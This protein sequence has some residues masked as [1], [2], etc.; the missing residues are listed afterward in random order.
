M[1]VE[2][3]GRL[4]AE[5]IEQDGSLRQK[6]VHGH[7]GSWPGHRDA[8]TWSRTLFWRGDDTS[9]PFS[10]AAMSARIQ[11]DGYR[12]GGRWCGRT[13]MSIPSTV[14]IFLPYIRRTRSAPLWIMQSAPA[15]VRENKRTVYVVR[16]AQNF[17]CGWHPPIRRRSKQIGS[18]GRESGS[19]VYN[20][21]HPCAIASGNSRCT[22]RPYYRGRRRGYHGSSHSRRCRGA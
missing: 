20:G 8:H 6:T 5:Q 18:G 9:S 15:F 3:T 12:H 16:S 7:A 19:P 11:P 10:R 1:W 13:A 14:R 21:E 4:R 17:S 22:H 2:Q